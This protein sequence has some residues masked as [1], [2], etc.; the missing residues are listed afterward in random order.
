VQIGFTNYG[1]EH[2]NIQVNQPSMED[3][4]I[5]ARLYEVITDSL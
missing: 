4:E 1:E 5:I 2:E 3:T